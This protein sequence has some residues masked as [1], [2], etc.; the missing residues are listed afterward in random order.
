MIR[1]V[2]TFQLEKFQKKILSHLL[3]Y[4]DD[5]R[6]NVPLLAIFKNGFAVSDVKSLIEKLIE[7]I[8][9]LKFC[10]GRI[11][12]EYVLMESHNPIEIDIRDSYGD[13]IN[14]NYYLKRAHQKRFD[15]GFKPLSHFTIVRH[16][17]SIYLISVF[18]H[19]IVDGISLDNIKCL[20]VDLTDH[21][22]KYRV[23]SPY[24]MLKQSVDASNIQNLDIPHSS[25]DPGIQKFY[26][27]NLLPELIRMSSESNATLSEVLLCVY[28]YA[29]KTVLS[30]DKIFVP[31]L[32]RN[33]ITELDSTGCFVDLLHIEISQGE[34]ISED[35]KNYR[36]QVFKNPSSAF[37]NH[38]APAD[39][40]L[41]SFREI[42]TTF[43]NEAGISFLSENE[44]FQTY[45]FLAPNKI[46][47]S[48][49]FELKTGNGQPKLEYALEYDSALFSPEKINEISS[50]VEYYI[51]GFCGQLSS[52]ELKSASDKNI[53][54]SIQALTVE[55]QRAPRI[56]Y[57]TADGNA[58]SYS[59]HQVRTLID[60]YKLQ[61]IDNQVHTL[62]IWAPK[63]LDVISIVYACYELRI[64]YIPLDVS[65]PRQKVELIREQC[66]ANALVLVDRKLSIE[67]FASEQMI[68]SAQ[69]VIYTSGS[70]GIPKGVKIQRDAVANLCHSMR[71]ALC[72][73][74]PLIIFSY[75]DLH[76]DMS[77]PD[78]YL[79][80]FSEGE[81]VIFDNERRSQS[82][83]LAAIISSV[84][85]SLFQCTP[86]TLGLFTPFQLRSL[87]IKHLIIGGERVSPRYSKDLLCN[88]DHLWNFYGPT[89][90]TVWCAYRE[91]RF[92][93][94]VDVERC[95]DGYGIEIF[96]DG[97]PCKAYEIGEIY[98]RGP[99]SSGYVD[100]QL[101]K[102]AF[103]RLT[104]D[105]VDY[106]Y[107]ASGDF[108]EFI[109]DKG[110]RIIGRKDDQIKLNGARIELSEV[111]LAIESIMG[112]Q[113]CTVL[114]DHAHNQ[115]LALVLSKI[116]DEN[117][118]SLMN[119]IEK[120]LPESKRPNQLIRVGKIPTNANGKKERDVEK[121]RE[122]LKFFCETP[123]EINPD[124]LVR[125]NLYES[126]ASIL[127]NALKL[128]EN[129]TFDSTFYQLGGSSFKAINIIQDL[130]N[131]GVRV[132]VKELLE[133]KRMS[134]FV[135]IVME[136]LQ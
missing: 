73:E 90:A 112:V 63:S 62:L 20:L 126:V 78:I 6:Y 87:K 54:Q 95:L 35:V 55:S 12:E 74:S 107:Y 83:F 75:A 105:A 129:S 8:A 106:N 61:L 81:I 1:M 108:A 64:C 79:P 70:T 122:C 40:V 88:V 58:L 36:E 85:P 123:K 121:I 41:Y 5:H 94:N 59:S 86:T 3:Q 57:F 18:H 7:H 71:K 45:D 92:T 69:Y 38:T 68:F 49:L 48:I 128:E 134:H 31:Y 9:E 34:D 84:K 46:G 13:E 66:S 114:Y 132:E 50:R 99:I 133:S 67:Y 72:L 15:V 109:P 110:L 115:L 16:D 116:Y 30:V 11:D 4:G 42:D 96:R 98:I 29:I 118:S 32:S 91:I 37:N 65:M 26:T 24:S 104:I 53:S 97:I 28:G 14:L 131:I 22:P 39:G 27:V 130:R 113:E 47:I 102:R 25:I 136:R 10:V 100:A 17:D 101:D 89:E 103:V 120:I 51:R 111:E 60:Q 76:F 119:E 21:P 93:D 135:D 2:R 82:T 127:T 125:D 124:S 23:H 56:R 44:L 19:L 117:I 33:S 77:V 43:G 52:I 80:Y